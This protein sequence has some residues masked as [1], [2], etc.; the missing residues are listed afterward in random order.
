MR[1]YAIKGPVSGEL[2]TYGGRILVHGDRGEMEFLFPAARVVPYGGDLPTLPIRD[3][4]H[5]AS[6]RW[7]LNRED[8][9]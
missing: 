2:V 3:H 1:R 5:M 4:P 9:R 7:P 8:F 6:V